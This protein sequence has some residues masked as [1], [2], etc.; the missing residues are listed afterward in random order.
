M[1][2]RLLRSTRHAKK[3]TPYPALARNSLW[4][5]TLRLKRKEP[6]PEGPGSLVGWELKNSGTL[7]EP[8]SETDSEQTGEQDAHT[9]N[10]Q[11]TALGTC[12]GQ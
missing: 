12:V 9:D 4:H 8:A 1:L 10:G 11:E 6:S 5:N 3:D 7:S 2:T